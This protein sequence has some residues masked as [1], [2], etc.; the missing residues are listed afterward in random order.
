MNKDSNIFILSMPRTGSS[1]LANL[2]QSAGYNTQISSDSLLLQPSEFNPDGYFEETG[3][4]LLNDQLIRCQYGSDKSFLHTP[5]PS[6]DRTNIKAA[7]VNPNF[8][9]DINEDSLSIPS[10]FEQDL[11]SFT[12]HSWDPWGLTRMAYGEKW[13]RCYK[14]YGCD[15]GQKIKKKIFEYSSTF[16]SSTGL[17]VKDP[18]LALTF[19]AFNIRDP[20]IIILR[21]EAEECLKSLRNHYGNKLFT[22]NLIPGESYCSNH[23]NYKIQPQKFGDYEK[24]YESCFR[25]AILTPGASVLEI[26]FSDIVTKGPR[27]NELEDFIDGKVDITRIRI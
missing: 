2:V 15:T 10:G 16:N 21:R 1:V 27:L 25:R 17:I 19:G 22:N 23:F 11:L 3:F 12:G 4:T 20:K 6:S 7:E 5:H 26:C 13:Y 9:Y 8:F 24:F 14:K 18:R